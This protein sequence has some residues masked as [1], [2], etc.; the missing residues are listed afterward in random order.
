M[1]AI[2]QG[3]DRAKFGMI[4]SIKFG[5]IELSAPKVRKEPFR[6]FAQRPVQRDL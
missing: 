4:D 3:G 5:P 2:D 1:R 6:L